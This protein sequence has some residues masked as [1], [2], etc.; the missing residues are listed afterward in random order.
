MEHQ[1]IYL[2]SLDV[3][4]SNTTFATEL[5]GIVINIS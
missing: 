4:I 5:N 1:L 2:V 3:T